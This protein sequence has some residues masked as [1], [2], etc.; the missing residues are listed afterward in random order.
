MQNGVRGSEE[1]EGGKCRVG[2][3]RGNERATYV[4]RASR[5]YLA[6]GTAGG[7]ERMSLMIRRGSEAR[8]GGVHEQRFELLA[9]HWIAASHSGC[10]R[11]GEER[12]IRVRVE[13]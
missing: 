9:E 10:E 5:S 13:E 8:M 4:R 1:K 12:R 11:G 2:A 3:V 7:V 6:E